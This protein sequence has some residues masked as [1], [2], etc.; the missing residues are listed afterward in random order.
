MFPNSYRDLVIP[1]HHIKMSLIGKSYGP[2]NLGQHIVDNLLP[3]IKNRIETYATDNPLNPPA[4][5]K[6]IEKYIRIYQSEINS[7]DRLKGLSASFLVLFYYKNEAVISVSMG[8]VFAFRISQEY[9]EYFVREMKRNAYFSTVSNNVYRH[10]GP[11]SQ[12]RAEK[13]IDELSAIPEP[14]KNV[15]IEPLNFV[16]RE[17]EVN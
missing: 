5:K 10:Y 15:P 17:N 9:S 11:H 2:F 6:L 12:K 14:P 1:N 7:I 13:F 4:L 16:R 8:P 3:Y